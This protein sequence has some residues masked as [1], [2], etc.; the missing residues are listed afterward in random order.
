MR[1]CGRRQSQRLGPCRQPEISNVLVQEHGH[2]WVLTRQLLSCTCTNRLFVD[3][4]N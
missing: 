4:G 2:I 3:R 1:R